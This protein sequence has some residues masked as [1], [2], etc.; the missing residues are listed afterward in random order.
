MR[1]YKKALAIGLSKEQSYQYVISAPSE[2]FWI[3]EERATSVILSLSKGKMITGKM[4]PSRKHMFLDIYA[5][6][7]TMSK[8]KPQLSTFDIIIEVLSKKAPEFYLTIG[9]AKVLIHKCRSG[10][11]ERRRHQSTL[12]PYRKQS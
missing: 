2:R 1:T 6:V 4:I 5:R 10:F 9:S 8:I 11:Y 7:S 12:K 3:S